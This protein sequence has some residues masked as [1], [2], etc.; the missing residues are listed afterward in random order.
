[1]TDPTTTVG[2]PYKS[3]RFK[4]CILMM[5]GLTTTVSMRV[6]L[7]MAVTCMVNSTAFTTPHQALLSNYTTDDS[8]PNLLGDAA[9]ATESG[10]NGELLWSPHMQSLLFSATF[11][12]AML[13][14]S[15]SGIIADRFGAKFI[16][17][18]VVL[19][20]AIVT[21]FTPLLANYSYYG[22]FAARIIMGIGEGFTFPCLNSIV[23]K[24]FP[25]G[26]RSSMAAI[27][28]SGNQMAMVTSTLISSWLCGSSWGWPSIF[29]L[30]GFLGFIWAIIWCIIFTSHP[31]SNKW[32]SEEEKNYLSLYVPKKGKKHVLLPWRSVITSIPF[33][34]ALSCQYTFNLQAG[35]LQAFVPTFLKEEL[36][37]PV[38]SNGLYSTIPFINQMV[39]KN[40]LGALADHLKRKG[41]LSHTTSAKLFQTIC[42]VGAGLSMLCLVLFS[43]CH[44]P[45]IVHIILGVLGFSL[46]SSV[47][48]FFTSM[49]SLAPG[50][51]GTI[52]SVAMIF[53]TLGNLS[54]PMI[55]SGLS[56]VTPDD[57]WTNLF[58]FCM[59]LNVLS[60]IFFFLCGSAEVQPWGR[61]KVA[62]VEMEK[63]ESS[64]N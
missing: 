28:T 5:L 12:G 26:E 6:D 61:D 55:L 37:L 30:F 57:K 27:F 16:L 56:L 60:G 46:S 19:D 8:C 20:Y 62:D 59:V 22:F 51:T 23:G 44:Y 14:T 53:G 47:P 31:S 41:I 1:M 13:T 32:I 17:L 11:Y 36:H 42:A 7:S 25:P 4:I 48:G 43:S 18:G 45:W 2:Y 33:W 15:F 3:L 38:A 9:V 50:H 10:Y 39:F 29:Y 64:G 52:G 35:I 54:G 58:L 21:L 49:L 63:S 34:A 40:V 24:W